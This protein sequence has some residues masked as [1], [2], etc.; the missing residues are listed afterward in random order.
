M[1]IR[2]HQVSHQAT[3]NASPVSWYVE[4]MRQLRADQPDVGFFV[5]CDVLAVKREI[6]EQFPGSVAL[7]HD[8]PYNSVPADE[9]CRCRHCVDA[10]DEHRAGEAGGVLGL[11]RRQVSDLDTANQAA[12]G[13]RAVGL[14]P[15]TSG[16][17]PPRTP[18]P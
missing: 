7:F 14:G 11:P 12:P 15:P 5:S 13:D 9:A 17:S 18:R 10:L 8:A 3:T 4:R 2:A 16:P 1:Q 6:V